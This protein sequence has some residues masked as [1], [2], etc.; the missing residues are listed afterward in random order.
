METVE[1]PR[2]ASSVRPRKFEHIT[3]KS[4]QKDAL[5]EILQ[6]VLG[7]RM[8]DRAEDGASWL[9]AGAEH[10]GFSVIRAEEDLLHHYAW[11]TDG[12]DAIRR[13]GD[14]LLANDLRFLWGPGHHGI[15]DNY[16]C[17]FLDPEGAIVEYSACIALIED[18]ASHEP[19]IWVDEPLSVNRWG[20]PPPPPEFLDGGVPIVHPLTANPA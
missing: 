4:S 14:H 19:G 20:N 15:G 13:I 8:S 16:F 7:L 17:Y 9:R 1:R 5:E 11:Q 12:W 6:E 3:V 10:H 18:E 2:S